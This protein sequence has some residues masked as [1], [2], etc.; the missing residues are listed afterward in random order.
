MRIPQRSGHLGAGR[1]LLLAVVLAAPGRVCV[2][3]PLETICAAFRAARTHFRHRQGGLS[4][5]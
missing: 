5:L 3:E 2:A 4:P 1:A